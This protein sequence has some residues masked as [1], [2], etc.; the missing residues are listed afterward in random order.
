MDAVFL[1]KTYHEVAHPV[2]LLK[3]LRAALRPGAKVGVID[4]NGNGSRITESAAM[5]SFA[6][7]RRP[8]TSCVEQYDL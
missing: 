6:K 5:W 4:R 7:R 1:L 8:G 3:N 2:E